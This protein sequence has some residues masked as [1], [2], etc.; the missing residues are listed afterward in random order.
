[1]VTAASSTWTDS[2]A[3]VDDAWGSVLVDA[4]CN[5]DE[6]DAFAGCCGGGIAC[7]EPDAVG[8]FAFEGAAAAEEEVVVLESFSPSGWTLN[9]LFI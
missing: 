8:V 5:A 2:T 3:V 9:D 7:A 6:V 4:F 1:M